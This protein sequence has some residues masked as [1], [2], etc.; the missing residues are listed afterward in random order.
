[1]D[2]KQSPKDSVAP[3]DNID[4]SNEYFVAPSAEIFSK[5]MPQVTLIKLVI[6]LIELHNLLIHR[7]LPIYQL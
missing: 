2:D 4:K 1:M 5:Q 6:R 3:S 7:S